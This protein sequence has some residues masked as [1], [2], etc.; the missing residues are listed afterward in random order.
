[1]QKSFFSVRNLVL[2][3]LFSALEIVL[4]RFLSISLWN[5]KIGFAFVPVVLAALYMGPLAAGFVGGISD[6]TGALL[7]PIGAYFPGFTLSALLIGLVYGLLLHKGYSVYRV[8]LAVII[9]QFIISLLLNSYWISLLYG[10]PYIALLPARF[11]QAALLSTLQILLIPLLHKHMPLLP[12]LF[13]RE[14]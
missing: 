1:M 5:I 7:F 2:I 11:G 9:T 4:S 14:A 8:I 6:L 13:K 12:Q 10:T 3:A